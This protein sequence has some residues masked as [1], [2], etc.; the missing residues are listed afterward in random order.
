MIGYHKTVKGHKVSVLFLLFWSIPA[1]TNSLS[2][3]SFFSMVLSEKQLLTAICLLNIC[4]FSLSA[5]DKA[6]VKDLCIELKL[7]GIGTDW[8]SVNFVTECGPLTVDADVWIIE[9]MF[10]MFNL[11]CKC[12]IFV[13]FV[14]KF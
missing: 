7:Y 13:L 4:S 10:V 14:N 5:V 9:P 6:I 3:L 8:F 1:V 11:V 12:D 2:E